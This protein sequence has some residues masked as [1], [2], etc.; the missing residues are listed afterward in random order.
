MLQALAVSYSS[1]DFDGF[2]DSLHRA[3]ER[4]SAAD[5]DIE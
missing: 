2:I 1:G 4:S 5:D 3:H